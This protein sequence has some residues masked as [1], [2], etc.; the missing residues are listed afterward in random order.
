MIENLQ[1]IFTIDS[2]DRIGESPVWDASE[3]RLLWSDHA[4]GVVHE[5][6]A[7]DGGAWRETR[8]WNLE[9]GLAAVIPRSQ[10]GLL[11]AA[12]TEI[13]LMD[14]SGALEPFVRLDV[15]PTQVTM[16]D[17]KCDP[18][19]RL[20]VGT[21]A[22]DLSASG[23]L[24][25]V[26][27]DETVTTMLEGLRLSNGLDWSPDGSTFYFIDSLE[28]SIDAFDFDVAQGGI[29]NRRTLVKLNR[30]GGG[31]NGMT[32]DHE[33]CLWVALTGGGEVRRYTADG[34]LVA[35]VGISS[36]GPTSC[37]FGGDD[38]D[39][40]FITS[41]SGRLPELARSVLGVAEDMLE[42]SGPQAGGLWVC[43]PGPTGAPATRFAG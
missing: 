22:R 21:M 32:V 33:G 13:L 8:R 9:R 23:A 41:R 24:Y 38:G 7:F 29:S 20:W 11:L 43:R 17:A 6:R 35:R 14:E 15:D 28:L 12:E 39:I 25:R 5:A 1:A 40:L 3:S 26:D 16:N 31:A 18:A 36:P 10:G 27:P 4:A 37:A 19:G 34:E 42:C 30:G 2:Q